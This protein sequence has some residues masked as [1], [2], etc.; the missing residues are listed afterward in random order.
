MATMEVQ[1]G[2]RRSF[3]N[4]HRASTATTSTIQPS[5]YEEDQ[6]ED[7]YEDEQYTSQFCRALYDYAAQDT[8]ALSFRKG[9]IIEVLSQQPSGWWDGLLRDERGWFPSNYVSLISEE[10][11]DLAFSGSD[12]SNPESTPSAAV[13]ASSRDSMIDMSSAMLRGNALQDDSLS[14]R[15]SFASSSMDDTSTTQ[16]S[17]ETPTSSSDFWM[18]QVASNG[19]VRDLIFISVQVKSHTYLHHSLDLLCQYQD[20]RAVARFTCRGR[21]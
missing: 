8:S 5:F 3:I 14:W 19:Q 9:D 12:F 7:M 10:E 6:A 20:R 11:A 21:R 2:Y 15:D 18:P 1:N 16:F 13:P 4:S 17:H